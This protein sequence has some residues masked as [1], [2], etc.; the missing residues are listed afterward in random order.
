MKKI[1]ILITGRI[2]FDL[3]SFNNYQ[4]KIVQ[5]HDVDL[6]VSYCKNTSS[7]LVEQFRNTFKPKKMI[8]SDEMYMNTEQYPLHPD[9]NPHRFKCMLLNRKK[10]FDLLKEHLKEDGSN[11]IQY[12]FVIS[13]RCDLFFHETLDL[14]K[15]IND[16]STLA[17]ATSI[18]DTADTTTA[19]ATDT[20]TNPDT[21]TSTSTT[22]TSSTAAATTIY[23]PS[24][25]DHHGG[26]NDQFAVGSLESLEIYCSLYDHLIPILSKGV[27]SFHPETILRYYLEKYH[28]MKVIRFRFNY[29]IRR[30]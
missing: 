28:P 21:T 2:Q 27:V 29:Y 15:I 19:T 20:S 10:A 9:T 17:T 1:A 11:Q 18:T 23:V 13:S 22:T 26:L 5:N 7:D 25:F 6:F 8:E 3:E 30:F 14:D 12:D 16:S 4:E 24:E